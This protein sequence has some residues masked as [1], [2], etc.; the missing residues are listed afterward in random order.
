[1][2]SQ[3]I[4]RKRGCLSVNRNMNQGM[5]CQR[6]GMSRPMGNCSGMQ[7]NR[8]D[9]NCGMMPDECRDRNCRTMQEERSEKS[10]KCMQEE[11][12]EK[13]C[14]HMQEACSERSRE[15]MQEDCKEKRA[16]IPDVIPA[17][18]REELLCFIDKISFVVYEM[19]LYLD[20]HPYEQEALQ[21]FHEN[22]RLREKALKLYSETYG[23]LTIATVDE[24]CTQ[25]WEWMQQPWPWEL[26]GGAC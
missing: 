11:R 16:A 4:L 12:S 2:S 1:M 25:S 5:N 20:T 3:T 21:Y 18:S 9:R 22:N 6:A 15:P 8:R 10:C 19:L 26:E 7:G 23:P 24:S 13:S 17:G 14:K